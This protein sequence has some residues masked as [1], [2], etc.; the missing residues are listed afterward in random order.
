MDI[1]VLCTLL[2]YFPKVDIRSIVV[3]YSAMS[4]PAKLSTD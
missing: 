1:V 2:V 3:Q 4:N